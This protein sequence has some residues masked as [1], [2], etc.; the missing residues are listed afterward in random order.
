MQSAVICT[1]LAPG[2]VMPEGCRI[3]ALLT[4]H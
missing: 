4:L 2:G 3:G 1:G